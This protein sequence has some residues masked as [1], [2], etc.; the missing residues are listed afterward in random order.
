M[1]PNEPI[2]HNHTY[3]NNT[4]AD[5]IY[6]RKLGQ[7][8]NHIVSPI[9]LTLGGIGNLL[10][11]L[12]LFKR[13]SKNPTLTYLCIL[14]VFDILVLFTGLLRIYLLNSLNKDIRTTSTF[15]CKIHI[16]LTYSFM[17]ISSY[18]LVAVTLN[19]L[20]IVLERTVVCQPR[21]QI[22][23]NCKFLLK[24]E[25][26]KLKIIVICIC[27]SVAIFNLP[28]LIYY[29][30]IQ[31]ENRKNDCTIDP[32]KHKNYYKYRTKHYGNLHLLLFIC[33][34]CLILIISNIF[35][36]RKVTQTAKSIL[37]SI[38]KSG[39]KKK[40]EQRTRLSI[41]LVVICLWFIVLKTPAS[42]Y[43]TF[44]EEEENKNYFPFTYQL[45]ML[46]N[47]T[48]HAVNFILYSIT[49]PD[50]R[51]EF[52]LFYLN[53]KKAIS[54]KKKSYYCFRNNIN[55]AVTKN[56]TNSNHRITTST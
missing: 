13:K 5:L 3:I 43:L 30:V 26:F 28:F 54:C 14:A 7:N 8:L 49:N 53:I 10:C 51:N 25:M 41:M 11:I 34:P 29:E 6:Y 52:K 21:K 19:R 45:F 24:K 37:G 9:L 16:Y 46:I 48:N 36:I 50:F 40:L 1:L 42:V 56:C 55:L 12:L 17:Q 23:N 2:S 35:I 15:A 38:S 33:I 39:K 22:G 4:N 18:V 20:L 47:Y 44:P 27:I 32:L 31:K